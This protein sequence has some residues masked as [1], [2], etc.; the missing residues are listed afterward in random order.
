MCRFVFSC[1]DFRRSCQP[2]V[3]R[4]FSLY[5]PVCEQSVNN[6]SATSGIPPLR[7]PARGVRSPISVGNSVPWDAFPVSLSG[8]RQ[9]TDLHPLKTDGSLGAKTDPGRYHAVTG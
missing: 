9:Q 2:G 6:I 4:F 7:T 3:L 5:W 1:K 8:V